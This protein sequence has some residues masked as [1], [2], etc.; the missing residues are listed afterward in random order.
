MLEKA[1]KRFGKYYDQR[2]ASQKLNVS[3]YYKANPPHHF[4][5][6]LETDCFETDHC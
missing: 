1:T 6:E 5:D 4:Y 2:Y 3:M